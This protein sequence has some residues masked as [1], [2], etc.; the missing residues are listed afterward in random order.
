MALGF[1]HSK[2]QSCYRHFIPTTFDKDDVFLCLLFVLLSQEFCRSQISSVL[3]FCLIL[4][5]KC[6]SKSQGLLEVIRAPK[7]WL[8]TR[9]QCKMLGQ[10]AL[11]GSRNQSRALAQSSFHPASLVSPA[12]VLMAW[13]A[14][15]ILIAAL[16]FELLLIDY[17]YGLSEKGWIVDS[18]ACQKRCKQGLLVMGMQKIYVRCCSE[19]GTLRESPLAGNCESLEWQ[20]YILWMLWCFLLCFN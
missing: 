9:V 6:A 11:G 10:T 17:C 5:R 13:K 19:P 7:L 12:I 2:K 8:L 18:T 14:M 16:V 3:G 1:F 4:G 20:L 15:C